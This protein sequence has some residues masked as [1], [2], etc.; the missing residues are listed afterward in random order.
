MKYACAGD[1]VVDLADGRIVGPG[2]IVNLS[3][4]EAK[5]NQELIDN[6]RLRPQPVHNKKKGG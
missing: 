6:E 2:E 1:H 3:E 5:D 4:D